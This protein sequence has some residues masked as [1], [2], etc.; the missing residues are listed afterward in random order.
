METKTNWNLIEN[1][2]LFRDF[3]LFQKEK[4]KFEHTWCGYN[5]FSNQIENEV[6]DNK[7]KE[8]SSSGNRYLHGMN[9]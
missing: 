2:V 4:I 9:R 7:T 6:I 3:V 5:F 1:K 8:T